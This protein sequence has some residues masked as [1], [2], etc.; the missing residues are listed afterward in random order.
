MN[1]L[2]ILAELHPLHRTLNSD[3]YAAAAAILQREFPWLTAE[4]YAAGSRAWTWTIPARWDVD[5]AYLETANGQT[6]I[7]DAANSP[8]HVVSYS[9]PT[10]MLIT[11]RNLRALGHL[12]TAPGAVPWVY[13]YYDRTWGLCASEETADAFVRD[14]EVYHAVIRSTFKN[15]PMLIQTARVGSNPRELL[16][17]AHLDHPAQAN[18]DLSGVLTALEVMSRLRRLRWSDE[19]LAVRVLIAPETIGSIAHLARHGYA[20]VAGGVFAEM[21]GSGGPLALHASSPVD[22]I[23]DLDRAAWNAFGSRGGPRRLAGEEP[24]NDERVLHSLGVPCVSVNRWPYPEYHT[25][26]DTPAIVSEAKLQE[27]A[28]VIEHAVGVFCS[29]H[30]TARTQPGTIF[31][32]GIG[33][34][35]RTN[36]LIE[37]ELG[38]DVLSIAE[39]VGVPYAEAY[40]RIASLEAKGAVTR[41]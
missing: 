9:V 10:N 27:A 37:R 20:N 19:W 13:R 41:A 28:D 11:G 4:A 5:E 38:L 16:L 35:D 17:M 7:V 24:A 36:Q 1:L 25:S 29:N 3:G 15:L 30:G 8:L 2:P 34:F 21:T 40:R 39:R 22:L 23:T 31:L 6:R 18:D 12:H 33:L 32:S 26:L 14:N